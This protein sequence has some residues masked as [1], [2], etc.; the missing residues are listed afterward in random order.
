[1]KLSGTPIENKS[2][3]LELAITFALDDLDK[4][5]RSQLLASLET[6]FKNE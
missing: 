4:G 1:M 6:D 5:K 3:L 2:A